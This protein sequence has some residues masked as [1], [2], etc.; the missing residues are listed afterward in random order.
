MLYIFGVGFFNQQIELFH[1]TMKEIKN[2]ARYEIFRLKPLTLTLFTWHTVCLVELKGL[3][4]TIKERIFPTHTPVVKFQVVADNVLYLS[5]PPA[6]MWQQILDN[7]ASL[8]QFIQRG[9]C[10]CGL[11]NGSWSR[12]GLWL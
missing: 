7:M 4:D 8:E 2:Q 6:K 10:G 11:F 3:I 9:K 12:I 5:F 1:R